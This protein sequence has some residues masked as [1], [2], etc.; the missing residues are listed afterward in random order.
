M[1]YADWIADD[2][3][4]AMTRVGEIGAPTLALCGAEDRL[5]PL[6]Y[7][8][9]L[10]ERMPDCRLTV[11]DGAGHWSFREQPGQFG[12]AVRAFLAGLPAR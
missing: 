12:R 9:F 11:I 7:H 4:D 6:K 5:T 3:F 8:R 10:Q 2:T 1:T